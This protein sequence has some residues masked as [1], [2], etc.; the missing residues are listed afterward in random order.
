MGKLIIK[1][2]LLMNGKTKATNLYLLSFQQLLL[3]YP[4][5]SLFYPETNK[6]KVN[7]CTTSSVTRQA[8]YWNPLHKRNGEADQGTLGV[9]LEV[10]IRKTGH[11]YSLLERIAQNKELWHTVVDNLCPRRSD[12]LRQID[13]QI[14]TCMHIFVSS[15]WRNK[16]FVLPFSGTFYNVILCAMYCKQLL[17]HHMCKFTRGPERADQSIE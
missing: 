5:I 14:Q 9:D 1:C 11:S 16:Y 15:T 7:V 3:L 8:L 4:C 6:G 10:D 13:R 12:G 2:C 17:L